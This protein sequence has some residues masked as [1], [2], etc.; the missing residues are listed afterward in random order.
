M[1]RQDDPNFDRN[2]ERQIAAT[3]PM[4]RQSVKVLVEALPSMMQAMGPVRQSMER[5]IANMPRPDYPKR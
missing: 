5:A 2:F 4:V 3:G 1:G